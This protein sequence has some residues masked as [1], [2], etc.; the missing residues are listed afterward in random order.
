VFSL[1]GRNIV[2][3]HFY[4]TVMLEMI[5]IVIMVTSRRFISHVN[6]KIHLQ[7][8]SR[9]MQQSFTAVTVFRRLLTAGAY[10][11]FQCSSFGFS[12]PSG[13]TA[14]SGTGPPHCRGFTITLRH[15]TLGRT[16][17]GEWSARHRDLYL[18]TH[19]TH[20]RQTSMP[21]AVFE[22]TIPESERPQTHALE[23]AVSR[24]G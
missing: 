6:M 20:K 7:S 11:H 21:L 15:T 14:P 9:Q 13:A 19:N 22:T 5:G 1:W 2:C 16:P 3:K 18:T 12:F 23:H 10:I 4:M 17:L 8:T 24:I